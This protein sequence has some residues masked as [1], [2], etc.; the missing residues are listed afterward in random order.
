MV[1]WY[2]WYTELKS[3][4][5]VIGSGFG[6][7]ALICGALFNARLN[8]NRD[9]ALRKEE[10][11]SLA[12]ALYG[13]IVLLR[14]EAAHVA[15]WVSHGRVR[16]KELKPHDLEALSLSEPMLYKAIATKI[17]LLDTDLVVA[18]T[19]FHKNFQEVRTWLPLLVHT[20]ERSPIWSETAV[21][22]PAVDAVNGILPALRKIE[23]IASIDRPAADLDLGHAEALIETEEIQIKLQRG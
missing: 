9:R 7:G 19:E 4:Q 11:I 22:K 14:L 5:G 1:D 17:G 6:F 18:I 15:R 20:E 10:A 8:R 16:D 3:W 12:A 21:L 13:E 2:F 23:R